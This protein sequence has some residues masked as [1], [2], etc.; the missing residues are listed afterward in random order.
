MNE[1]PT[2]NTPEGFSIVE[3]HFSDITTPEKF[4]H[5]HSDLFS[6]AKLRWLIRQ[7]EHN[8]LS[9]AGAIVKCGR[10]I[11]IVRSKF[12]EWLITNKA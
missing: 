11:L 9:K 6:Q 1:L 5:E 4:A 8:G 2:R 10:S 7:R 12:Y 3:S